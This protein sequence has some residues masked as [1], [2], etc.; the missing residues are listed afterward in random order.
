MRLGK[1][2][3]HFLSLVPIYKHSLSR[4]CYDGKVKE[5]QMVGAGSTRERGARAYIFFNG[6]PESEG[7]D[8]DG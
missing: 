8:L 4:F 2:S 6:K 7:M 3:G 1:Y 5:D